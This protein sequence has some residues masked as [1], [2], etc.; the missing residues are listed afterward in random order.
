MTA[1]MNIVEYSKA[2]N[3]GEDLKR[4]IIEMYAG[5]SSILAALPMI[6]IQGN[7][8]KYNVETQYPGVGFRGVNESW[9]PST[10]IINSLV[11]ALVITGGELDVDVFLVKTMGAGRRAIEEASKVRALALAWTN[12]FINGNTASDPR[13]FDGLQTRITGSQLLSAGS[14]ANGAALSLEKMDELL[15]Q[16]DNP[17]HLIMNRKMARRF[18]AAAR[19]PAVSGYVTWTKDQL[20]QRVMQYNDIPILTVDKDN[21]DADILGFDEPASSGTDTATSI[22][23]V[24]MG[25]NGLCGLQNGTIDVR[26][27]GEL[28]SQPLMR[29]RVEWYTGMAIFN[30]RSAARLQHIGDLA[31]TA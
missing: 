6:Q 20:G 18:S 16:V 30:G 3:N 28:Q 11:E 27:L 26:D 1:A 7:A 19:T 13:E 15:D 22:Y 17:T 14:T 23:A 24:S 31:I 5:S 8:L 29:T 25:P 9:T 10:G 4:G 12:K 2:L 21:N